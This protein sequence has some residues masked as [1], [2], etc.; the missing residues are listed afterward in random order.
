VQVVEPGAARQPLGQVLQGQRPVRL[1]ERLPLLVGDD[2]QRM[3]VALEVAP[4]LLEGLADALGN[5]AV[6]TRPS[7]TSGRVRRCSRTSGASLA[8]FMTGR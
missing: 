4:F 6:G 2:D 8:L 5:E 1:G 3:D 7:T